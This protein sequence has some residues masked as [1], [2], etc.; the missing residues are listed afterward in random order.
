MFGRLAAGSLH[1]LIVIGLTLR[2]TGKTAW[3]G[4]TSVIGI[5]EV[6]VYA[7]LGLI[8]W[9]CWPVWQPGSF[10]VPGAVMLWLYIPS[11]RPFIERPPPVVVRRKET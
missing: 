4:F 3:A 7:A 1:F 2:R 6:C 11:R 5:E 9:G 8:A 10:L